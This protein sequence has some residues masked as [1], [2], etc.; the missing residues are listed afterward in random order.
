MV[1]KSRVFP[2]LASAVFLMLTLW[3]PLDGGSAVA[4]PSSPGYW[5]QAGD[6]G[7]FAFGHAPFLGSATQQCSFQCWG[8]DATADGKGYWIADNYPA[9]DPNQIRLYGFGS[10]FDVTVP[11]PDGGPLALTST[12]SDKG[13]WILLTDGT[14]VPFGDAQW[15]GDGSGLGLYGVTRPP[16]GS[17]LFYFV[18]I[19]STPDGKGYWLAGED[20][21]VFAYGDASYYGSMG[22]KSVNTPVTGIARTNDG[23]GYWLTSS[24]GGVFSFG[25]AG[26]QG[27][28][29]GKPLNDLMIGIAADPLGTGYW[30]VAQ[31]GGVF[32]FGDAPFLGSMA[33]RSLARPI[34]GIAA[35]G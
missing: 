33:N 8:F 6:G 9:T 15:F 28:M 13:G 22:G 19:V 31:D 5:L 14:V 23:H 29:A 12:P 11:N 2:I 32:A 25:D 10:A 1:M 18:G 27:S 4:A 20:G 24:D 35:G 16:F 34:H 17:F 30:T 26:F 7:V 21:G 3:A